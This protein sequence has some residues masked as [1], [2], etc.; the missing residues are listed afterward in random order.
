[1]NNK[2]VFDG[3][4]KELIEEAKFLTNKLRSSNDSKVKLDATRLLKDTLSLIKE[5]DWKLM[6][7]EYETDG[8]KEV[9]VWEQNYDGRIRN[10]KTW[11]VHKEYCG[12]K[13][14]DNEG[15][16]KLYLTQDDILSKLKDEDKQKYSK[17]SFDGLKCNDENI[18]EM[19]CRVY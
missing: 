7:S 16:V 6:Y 3:T 4:V 15:F 12:I 1:M 11:V 9:A 18:L 8:H 2:N 13:V 19:E 17:V 5:Y 14:Y 10:H